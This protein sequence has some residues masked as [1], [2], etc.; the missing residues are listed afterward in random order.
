MEARCTCL[1]ISVQCFS[2]KYQHRVQF[3]SH[4][5]QSGLNRADNLYVQSSRKPRGKTHLASP[6]CV[7]VT[8]SKS[9]EAQN[10]QYISVGSPVSIGLTHL[11]LSLLFS[12]PFGPNM[13]NQKHFQ[14]YVHVYELLKWPVVPF[15]KV[16]AKIDWSVC[17]MLQ[18]S[19][20]FFFLLQQTSN[21]QIVLLECIGMAD[22]PS[23]MK[24]TQQKLSSE[25]KRMRMLM[26]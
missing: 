26:L 8:H 12:L 4:V 5:K 1:P 3:C 10:Q 7:G 18:D 17:K 11:L 6:P 15:M 9:C 20:G 19:Q 25:F 21:R 2:H 24:I 22:V 16:Q 14:I 13:Q 23:A